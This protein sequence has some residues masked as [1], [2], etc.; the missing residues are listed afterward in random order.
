VSN[1]TATDTGGAV[2]PN[3]L[4]I[5]NTESNGRYLTRCR[6]EGIAP[7]P[8][9]FPEKLPEYFI[10][11]LTNPDD[12]VLDPFGGS[13]ITG[14]VAEKLGRRWICCDTSEEYLR[15]AALR[16]PI[17]ENR[18]SKPATYSTKTPCAVPVDEEKEPLVRDGGRSR[19]AK[20]AK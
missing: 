6:E 8:A 12:T 15:G 5:A 3:L 10:R 18:I 17:A 19:P 2:P 7:H 11:M 16:F 1:R 20:G 13:C 14:A 9:R 4:V